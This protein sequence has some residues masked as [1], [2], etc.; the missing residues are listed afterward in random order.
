MRQREFLTSVGGAVAVACWSR[1][2]CGQAQSKRPLIVWPGWMATRK[3]L[4][5]RAALW[6]GFTW[7]LACAAFSWSTQT[8][9]HSWYPEECCNDNDCAPVESIARFFPAGGGPAQWIVT[10]KH[11]TALVPEGFPVRASKDGRMHVC[12]RHSASDPFGDMGVVCLFV[13]D[14]M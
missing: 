7:I 5:A 6:L 11:G 12:L 1:A 8:L 10:S 14:S 2:G 13:P 4:R 9:A 3:G